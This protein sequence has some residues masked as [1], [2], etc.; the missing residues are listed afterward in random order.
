[1]R[2]PS[3]VLEMLASLPTVGYF[4]KGPIATEPTALA[5]IALA[6]AE[7]HD[8]AKRHLQWLVQIQSKDGSVGVFADQGG[9]AWA[10]GLA[11]IAWLLWE[12][13]T[14]SL[15]FQPC[16]ASALHWILETHGTT[17][18]RSP[19]LGHDPTLIGWSWA[20]GTHSW[21]EPTVFQVLALK[22]AQLHAHPR[23]R[24]GAA[25]I[26]DRQLPDGGCNYGNTFVLGQKLL[27]HI[28]PTALALLALW[29]ES[30]DS[31]RTMSLTYLR[32][33]WSDI[34]GLNSRCFAAMALRTY[35]DPSTPN[36]F[37]INFDGIRDLNLSGY[38]LALL[39]MTEFPQC[40]LL[41]WHSHPLSAMS[42]RTL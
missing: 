22:F 16:V 4:P 33:Q 27:P 8:A 40:P 23:T 32:R 20:D 17:M 28:Q 19:Q 38:Q 15:E 12:R 2:N 30:L 7:Q 29:N 18:P 37:E 5:A 10:T 35:A 14:A 34:R 6:T 13:T 31:R 9:P 3:P 42:T 39:A 11:T 25:L 1:M 24:E 21:I 36:A 41:A 26:L